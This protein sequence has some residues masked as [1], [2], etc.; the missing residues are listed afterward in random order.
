MFL[1]R[2][3]GDTI[4]YDDGQQNVWWCEIL[5]DWFFLF[6]GKMKKLIFYNDGQRNGW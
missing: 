1:V 4:F 6:I 2:C 5:Y 3:I